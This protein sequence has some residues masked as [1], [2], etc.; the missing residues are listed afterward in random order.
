M[1]EVVGR[2]YFVGLKIDE[3][4]EALGVSPRTGDLDWRMAR[5]W[6]H[7]ALSED[8]KPHPQE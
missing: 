8:T 4:A 1:G 2:G 5:A 7:R 6:L 3:T